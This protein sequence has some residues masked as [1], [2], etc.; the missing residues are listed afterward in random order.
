MLDSMCRKLTT[1]ASCRRWPLA[2]FFNVLDI[3]AINAWII[4]KK[5]TGST[6]S[7]RRFLHKLAE[8]LF[9]V[10]DTML[11]P[12]QEDLQPVAKRP[13]LDERVACVVATNCN[14]NKTSTECVLC[15]KAVCGSCMADICR[16]CYSD[17]RPAASK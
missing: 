16:K 13:K 8:E 6:M 9:G 17:V 1:K 12:L 7:R 2:V 10:N 15:K 11:Q 5:R 14:R 4:Y 3:A